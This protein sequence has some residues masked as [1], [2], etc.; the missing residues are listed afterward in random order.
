MPTAPSSVPSDIDEE[1][2]GPTPLPAPIQAVVPRSRYVAPPAP[3][4]PPTGTT[5][6]LLP[7][8]GI[9][10]GEPANP[11]PL[12]WSDDPTERTTQVRADYDKRHREAWDQSHPFSPSGTYVPP[13]EYSYQIAGQQADQEVYARQIQQRRDNVATQ[14]ATQAAGREEQR[15]RNAQRESDFRSTGQQFYTDPYGEYQPVVEAGT[16]RNLYHPTTWEDG[17]THPETGEPTLIKRDKYGQ[18]QYKTPQMV[19]GHPTDSQLYYDFGNGDLRPAGEISALM[20][21]SN[22]RVAKMATMQ[23][24]RRNESMRKEAL[25]AMTAVAAAHKGDYEQAELRRDE[26]KGQVDA[27][28][29]QQ[30]TAPNPEIEKQISVLE[31]ERAFLNQQLRPDGE[32]SR[33]KRKA[34]LELALETARLKHAQYSDSA[35]L[36]RQTLREQGVSEDAD[37]TLKEHLALRDKWGQALSNSTQAVTQDAVASRKMAAGLVPPVEPEAPPAAQQSPFKAMARSV[38]T[39][40]GSIAKGLAAVGQSYVPTTEMGDLVKG[41]EEEQARKRA[42]APSARMKEI[43]DDP[44][45]EWGTAMQQAAQGAFYLSP[46]EKR[47]ML[48]HLGEGVGGFVPL[49]ASG[50]LA[51]VTAALQTVG[52]EM[53]RIYNDRVAAGATPDVAADFAVRRS[54]VSGA[55]QGALFEIMP[56]PLRALGD[57]AISKFTQGTLGRILANRVAQAGEGAAM[58]A[59]SAA[60]GNVVAERPVGEGVGEAA[61]GLGT[62]QA[63]MPRGG[64]PAPRPGEPA[65]PGGEPIAPRPQPQLGPGGE[66]V[67]PP[68]GTLPPAPERPLL[69]AGEPRV[70]EPTAPPRTVEEANA[71]LLRLAEREPQV[72]EWLNQSE[73]VTPDENPAEIPRAAEAVAGEVAPAADTAPVAPPSGEAAAEKVSPRENATGAAPQGEAASPETAPTREQDV[74]R[75]GEIQNRFAELQKTGAHGLDSPEVQSLF[76]ENEAIKNRHGGMPPVAETTQP[77]SENALPKR[78]PT[79]ILQR[80][81]APTGEAGGERE[82]VEPSQQG[83]EAPREKAPEARSEAVSEAVAE[84]L[85]PARM[86]PAD[87]LAELAANGVKEINGKPLAEANSAEVINALGKLRRGQLDTQ[88]TDIVD[89]LRSAKKIKPGMVNSPDPF[90]LAHDA[91]IDIA[92][93]AI[94][95]GRAIKDV[96]KLAVARFRALHPDATK[97]Q[98]AQVEETVMHAQESPV[99]Q[100]GPSQKKTDVEKSKVPES[101]RARGVKAEDIEYPIRHQNERVAEAKEIIAKDGA[102]KAEAKLADRNLDPD[103]RVAIAGELTKDIKARIGKA[104]PEEMAALTDELNRVVRAWQSNVSAPSGQGVAMHNR[105]YQDLGVGAMSEYVRNVQKKNERKLGGET[106]EAAI[107]DVVDGAKAAA[108]ESDINAVIERLKKKHSTRP[109]RQVLDALQKKV[110]TISELKKSG[111]LNREDL[112]DLVGKELGIE[113]PSPAKLKT[114]AE[115]SDRIDN[116]KTPAEKARAEMDLADAS[117]I[118][119]GDHKADLEATIFTAN[120]FSGLTTQASN[121]GGTLMQTLMQ[122]GTLI[123]QNLGKPS[124]IAALAKGAVEGIPIGLQ[125]AG[126]ILKTGLG[127][128]DFQKTGQGGA[129]ESGTPTKTQIELADYGRYY[130]GMNDTVAKALNLTRVVPSKYLFR[131]M[132]A[133][134]STYYYTAREAYARFVATKLME[135]EFKG[136]ELDN[137]VREKLHL[138]PEQFKAAKAMAAKEGYEGIDL[139]RRTLEIIEERRRGSDVGAAAAERSEQFGAESTFNQEPTGLPGVIYHGLKYLVNETR[140]GG[141]PLLKP[142]AVALRTPTNVYNE[143]LNYT[144]IGGLRAVAGMRGEGMRNAEWKTFNQEERQQLYIKS[145]IGSAMMAAAMTGVANGTI[146]ITA[147]GP[148]SGDHKRQLQSGGWIP[149]SIKIGDKRIS[150]KDSPLVI[151]LSILGH[152]A[153]AVRYQKQKADLVMGDKVADAMLTSPR[154][155][156]D[157]SMLTGTASAMDAAAGNKQGIRKMEGLLGSIPANLVIPYSRLLRQIDQIFDPKTYTRNPVVNA[158][159]F[160]RRQGEAETDVQGRAREY[161]PLN[162]YASAEKADPVD[163][164]VREKNV[165]IPEVGKDARLEQPVVTAAQIKAREAAGAPPPKIGER[166]IM[167][168]DERELYRK[169]SGQRIRVR[170][171][172]IAPRLRMLSQEEAQKQINEIAH[173]E[174]QNVLGRIPSAVA[175]ARR[176]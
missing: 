64:G 42:L 27:L 22:P 123:P 162:R 134:D 124:R 45:H 44:L 32:L 151:P 80:E 175:A 84:P 19:A 61:A 28:V 63:L 168:D 142:V 39:A 138:K 60:A 26:I 118:F 30:A 78:S 5:G 113:K 145:A 101:L 34:A 54:L 77:V 170:L 106:T 76:A 173:E 59:T 38:G 110:K 155:I 81:Q 52:D 1:E 158:I 10:P 122:L 97:E 103:T 36:R 20:A 31:T 144:P 2:D 66:P 152:I 160:A 88:K 137:A 24:H 169:L 111:A 73:P 171:Q 12:A 37:P 149:Y 102:K 49:V 7:Q 50:P 23:N 115:I 6:G 133:V 120:L 8:H 117:E 140:L 40:I 139:G 92:I 71:H 94:K 176:R 136:A 143:F 62:L 58:G 126:A 14:R 125:E 148:E 4:A 147:D 159:P 100:A 167:S 130:P 18:R 68:Q 16:G 163:R 13:S 112:T 29:E 65:A 108:G 86:K 150:Y 131:F 105:V 109:A 91:A 11:G 89:H 48:T 21:S 153:D 114:I 129:T 79:E 57:A 119:K 87:R 41:A 51:P 15:A 25:E 72:A 69:G 46:E 85:P 67:V 174:R 157:T 83:A 164:L 104:R 53:E 99:Q 141:V 166:P 121:A 132:R 135:G 116:A 43:T 47:G 17:G 55:A 95:A 161:N 165:F 74:T 156:F 90:T 154:V 3:A 82:R 75:Y 146:D 93:A 56:K 35:E 107:K 96:V 9:K 172:A 127:T 128:R 70:V 98:V 33:L